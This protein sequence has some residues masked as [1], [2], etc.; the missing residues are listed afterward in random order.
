MPEYA[1]VVFETQ[2]SEMA[3]VSKEDFSVELDYNELL[4]ASDN[5]ARL[6]VV[7]CPA[8]VFRKYMN[9]VPE[10]LDALP[11]DRRKNI[12]SEAVTHEN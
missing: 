9:V 8:Y 5:K 1:T 6:K 4:A 2:K 3:L 7:E 11:G 10:F 12:L